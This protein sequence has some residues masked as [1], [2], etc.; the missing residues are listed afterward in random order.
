MKEKGNVVGKDVAKLL[1]KKNGR[2]TARHMSDRRK[3]TEGHGPETGKEVV[4]KEEE[5][6]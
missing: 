5:I 4:R 6:L 3:Q 2:V 1:N